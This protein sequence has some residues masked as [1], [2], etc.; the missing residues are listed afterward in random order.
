MADTSAPAMGRT[1]LR[2][3]AQPSPR[4]SLV[5]EYARAYALRLARRLAGRAALRRAELRARAYCVIAADRL[6]RRGTT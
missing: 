4:P 3:P 1:I 2:V 6:T 5:H